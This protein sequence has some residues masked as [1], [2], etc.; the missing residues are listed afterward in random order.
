MDER[1][2]C[3]KTGDQNIGGINFFDIVAV[4]YGLFVYRPNPNYGHQNRTIEEND[5]ECLGIFDY[6]STLLPRYTVSKKNQYFNTTTQTAQL[7]I[8]RY[9]ELL[10]NNGFLIDFFPWEHAKLNGIQFVNMLPINAI[11][12]LSVSDF[13]MYKPR[14]FFP[15]FEV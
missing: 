7:G 2:I 4:P 12:F 1:N 6:S 15:V 10:Q 14:K 8:Q 11:F 13:K 5:N 3:N 9:I